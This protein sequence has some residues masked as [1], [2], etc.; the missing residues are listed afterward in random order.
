MM[1][2][3]ALAPVTTR[4][5]HCRPC[6]EPGVRG[7]R[8]GHSLHSVSR[9]EKEVFQEPVGYMSLEWKVALILYFLTI[10]IFGDK[11]MSIGTCEIRI[12]TGDHPPPHADAAPCARGS[13]GPRWARVAVQSRTV[14]Y[15]LLRHLLSTG[16]SSGDDRQAAEDLTQ[17]VNSHVTVPCRN[18]LCLHGGTAGFSVPQPRA[19]LR[20]CLPC[21]S[22]HWSVRVLGVMYFLTNFVETQLAKM[23]TWPGCNVGRF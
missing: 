11:I 19:R 4:Q 3:E 13:R 20:W 16:Y 2:S 18:G 15:M 14:C 22:P 23:K 12:K 1:A 21:L 8:C 5:C 10:K 9:V 6:R 7:P 17:D